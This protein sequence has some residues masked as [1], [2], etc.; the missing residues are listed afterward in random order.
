MAQRAP[1]RAPDPQ[2]A[3]RL[4]AQRQAQLRQQLEV[5]QLSRRPMARPFPPPPRPAFANADRNSQFPIV[6]ATDPEDI[7]KGDVRFAQCLEIYG[8][9]T[10]QTWRTQECIVHSQCAP[11]NGTKLL[12]CPTICSTMCVVLPPQSCVD[13]HIAMYPEAELPQTA[14]AQELQQMQ[15]IYNQE[16]L[17]HHDYLNR[18]R[19]SLPPNPTKNNVQN[20]NVQNFPGWAIAG[21][22]VGV[23]VVAVALVFVVMMEA[24]FRRQLQEELV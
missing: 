9:C 5:Q 23:V 13:L 7:P 6:T 15:T 8:S 12:C 14:S 22:V 20:N 24:R 11:V 16:C 19:N 21:V 2:L 18:V 4:E 1:G 17:Q 3:Q 10:D